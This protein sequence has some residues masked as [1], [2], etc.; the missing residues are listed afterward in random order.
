MLSV[1]ASETIACTPDELLAFVMDPERYATVDRKIRPV[2]WVRRDGDFCEFGFRP[3]LVGI[4]GPPAVSHMSLTPGERVDARLAPAPAN[5]LTRL[6][7]D[8]D[9]SFAVTAVEGGT[10]LVRRLNYRFRPAVRWL[11]EPLLRRALARDVREDVKLAKQHLE[12]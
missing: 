5:R 12:S 8:L 10:R 11:A 4:P 7:L 6:L 2:R 3:S 1:E 9:A